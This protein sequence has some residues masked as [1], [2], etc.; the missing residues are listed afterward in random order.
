M[1]TKR[2]AIVWFRN[3]LRLH[4]NVALTEAL[5]SAIE[6]I[7]V[8]IFDNRWF[9]SETSYGFPK[10]GPHRTRFIIES[11]QELR[12]NLRRHNGDLVVR[13]GKTEHIL[14]ELAKKVKSSWIFCNRERTPEEV[15]IQDALEEK[16]WS[17]GQELRFSR[18]KMLY[19]T[20]D[21]PFPI[22]HVPDS[23]TQFRKETERYVGVREPLPPPHHS[24]AQWTVDL[25]PGEI[26]T[27]A[28]F[29]L[30]ELNQTALGVMSFRGGEREGLKRLQYYL[31]ETD[32]AQNYRE[33]RSGLLGGDYSTKFSPWLAQGCLSPKMIYHELKKYEAQRGANK[34]TYELFL[35]L[36]WR[37]FY[38]FMAKKHGRVI[39]RKEGVHGNSKP[40]WSDDFRILQRWIDG[41]T[42]IPF[43]DANMKELATTGYLSNRGRQNV[44]SFLVHDLQVNWQ[45]GAEYFES[46]LIDYDVTSNWGN[47]NQ[48]AGV[49][50]D[51]REERPVNILSQA[52][53]YDPDGSYVKHWLPELRDLPAD[54]VHN[55]AS[56]SEQER[57][58]FDLNGHYQNAII[59]PEQLVRSR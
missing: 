36:M 33:T 14:F 3:D 45:M 13:V 57:K 27:P 19:H 31:W 35:S 39:F 9:H 51:P 52:R 28:D 47:W 24:F 56:L 2:R 46:M 20:A 16:L 21:L 41:E 10:V 58:A 12:Q 18:G 40:T 32:L 55:P 25:D 29:G 7:P 5:S 54:K 44:A 15:S 22:Q 50:S 26:P 34:S 37:D 23:F 43:I 4:D 17:I 1:Q 48:I 11:I 42:G 8:Y 30:E 59:D 49:G 6:V 38:R 53:R